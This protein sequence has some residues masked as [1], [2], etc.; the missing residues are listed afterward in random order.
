MA[1]MF[2]CM[3][4]VNNMTQLEATLDHSLNKDGSHWEADEE[5][6]SSHSTDMSFH[7][8][9]LTL[10]Q[11]EAAGWSAGGAGGG[12]SGWGL[13]GK[14]WISACDRWTCTSPKTSRWENKRVMNQPPAHSS[15]SHMVSPLCA[16]FTTKY[17]QWG[18]YWRI[19]W[20]F[21][22]L[23]SG[24]C[25]QNCYHNFQNNK[26]GIAKLLVFPDHQ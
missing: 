15:L 11:G 16:C 20:V 7:H 2:P 14:L 13:L 10:A 24:N 19:L 22:Y 23:L 18:L 5:L 6:A 3:F 4:P 1:E 17:P 9:R 8:W 26:S 12:G 21:S 25:D